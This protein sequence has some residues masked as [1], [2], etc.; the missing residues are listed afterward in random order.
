MP[1]AALRPPRPPT[2]RWSGIHQL[3]VLVPL[4]TLLVAPSVGREQAT[5]VIRDPCDTQLLG[6][7]DDPLAY[8]RRGDRCE[9]VYVREVAGTGGLSVVGFSTREPFPI[10]PGQPL[11]VAWHAPA[12]ASVFLRAI[13]L[14]RR[15]YYRMDASR[16]AGDPVFEWPTEVLE[17]LKLESR[18]IAL[19]AWIQERIGEREQAVYVPVRI[20]AGRSPETIPPPRYAIQIVPGTELEEIYVTLAAV[21][22][23]GR[24]RSVVVRDQPLGRGFYPAERVIP[25]P[26]PR[27]PSAGLYRLQLNAVAAG[28]VPASRSLYF[29]H[30]DR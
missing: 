26:L 19:V 28:D 7:A 30:T 4:C 17:A 21:D 13:S 16:P 20:G 11:M 22:E 29:L 23:T 24:D 27:L 6:Q 14:R 5:T 25:I 8:A 15:L 10:V 1:V 12:D 2:G 9:G 18:E 3:W